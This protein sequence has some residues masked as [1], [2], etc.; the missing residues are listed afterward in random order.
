M[1][2]ALAGVQAELVRLHALGPELAS[3]LIP[4]Q[5][6]TMRELSTQL[7]QFEQEVSQLSL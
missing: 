1:A 6:R 5:L 2:A 4:A 3:Q 7:N